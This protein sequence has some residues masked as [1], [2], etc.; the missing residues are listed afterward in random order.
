MMKKIIATLTL[1]FLA[2][3][4]FAA[5]IPRVVTECGP[6]VTGVTD[7]AMTVVWISS[8]RKSVV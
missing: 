7:D 4:S 8:D 3:A 6:W 2:A 1:A 5:D